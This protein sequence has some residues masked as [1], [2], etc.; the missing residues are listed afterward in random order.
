MYL[1]FCNLEKSK[2]QQQDS[3]MA[4][5]DSESNVIEDVNSTDSDKAADSS[6]G[7]NNY[8]GKYFRRLFLNLYI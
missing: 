2:Q 3:K 1:D 4:S 6:S 5:S 8:S 7:S